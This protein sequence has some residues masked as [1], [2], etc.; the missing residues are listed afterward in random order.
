MLLPSSRRHRKLLTMIT[1]I[2]PEPDCLFRAP[3]FSLIILTARF[4]KPLHLVARIITLHFRRFPIPDIEP[5]MP[6]LFDF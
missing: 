6:G 2:R 5:H 3:A 4:T 1:H